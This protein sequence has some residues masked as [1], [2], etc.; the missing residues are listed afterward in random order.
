MKI[1]LSLLL[2]FWSVSI[3]IAGVPCEKREP[4]E[5]EEM[6]K[7]KLA[8][9]YCDLK[10]RSD[11]NQESI[12]SIEDFSFMEDAQVCMEEMLKAERAY[13]DRFG[14]DLPQCDR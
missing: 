3:C 1:I 2:C 14:G 6:D 10:S 8:M 9:T 7:E 13:K 5:L 12:G 4:A 11:A